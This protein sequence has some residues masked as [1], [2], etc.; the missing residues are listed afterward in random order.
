ME[1]DVYRVPGEK[2]LFPMRP[3][4]AFRKTEDPQKAIE[5]ILKY[6]EKKPD[7]LIVTWL[8]NVT[9]MTLESYPADVPQKYL[10][11]PSAFESNEDVGRF[12]PGNMIEFTLVVTKTSSYLESVHIHQYESIEQDPLAARR[13][14]LVAWFVDPASAP[15]ER[16]A[17]SAIRP[18]RGFV[19][20][21]VKES[22][23]EE[24]IKTDCFLFGIT[25]CR[26]WRSASRMRRTKLDVST[27]QLMVLRLGMS[28]S[29]VVAIA[30]LAAHRRY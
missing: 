14:K 5:Y 20:R 28:E 26:S 17:L 6:L 4:N 9:Y 3:G 25:V 16:Y 29:A 7:D 2:C 18:N 8:L 30:L 27:L 22:V 1:N 19:S 12:V 15:R 23:E 11:P 24:K 13:L 10:V 21:E